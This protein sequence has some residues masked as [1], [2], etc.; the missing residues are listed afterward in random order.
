MSNLPDHLG[1][2]VYGNVDI[3]LVR[4]LKNKF[5]IKSLI[6]IGCGDGVASQKY[7][8]EFDIECYGVDGDWTRLP[9]T[10]EFIL[11]DFSQGK[12]EFEP[13]DFSF[14]CAYSI[15]FL[16]HVEEKYQ[17]NYMDL[18]SRGNL[19]VVTAALPGQGG[20]HHVNCRPQE[21]WHKVFEKYGYMYLSVETEEARKISN[22]KT[23][24]GNPQ[25]QW[26]KNT[27]MIFKK[28]K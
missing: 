3:D 2:Q 4:Y 21:Y 10:P 18:F 19:C 16:E 27:G 8:E 26:F 25:N 12:L 17:D 22:N 13:K 1:G 15:E 11:H 14:D 23:S 9:K 5:E 7:A 24:Q 28:D 20:H 6:D